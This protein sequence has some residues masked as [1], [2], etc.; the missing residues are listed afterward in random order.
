MLSRGHRR[1]CLFA[2]ASL[3]VCVVSRAAPYSGLSLGAAGTASSMNTDAAAAAQ[4]STQQAQEWIERVWG[5]LPTR[6]REQLRQFGT[7]VF[8][9]GYEAMIEEYFK[10]LAEEAND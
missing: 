3:I 4:R 9:P 8:L 7:D 5:N 6:Q 1:W 2:A 10:R